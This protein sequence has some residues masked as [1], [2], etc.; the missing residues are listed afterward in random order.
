MYYTGQ[1]AEALLK[2]GEKLV[3]P[4]D[5]YWTISRPKDVG[6]ALVPFEK[7]QGAASIA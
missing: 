4:D 2:Q 6:K 7:I 1:K 3:K 5:V